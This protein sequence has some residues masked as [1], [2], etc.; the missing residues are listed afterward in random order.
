M[1]TRSTVILAAALRTKWAPLSIPIS[2]LLVGLAFR[3]AGMLPGWATLLIASGIIGG[4]M[5]AYT[6]I[7]D[8]HERT[9]DLQAL[10]TSDD[11]KW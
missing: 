2:L 10:R 7:Y 5:T 11:A 9:L 1:T 8:S 6:V 3:R 4:A